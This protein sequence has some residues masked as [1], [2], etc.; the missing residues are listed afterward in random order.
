MLDQKFLRPKNFTKITADSRQVIPGAVFFAISGNKIDGKTYID[1]A[2]KAG[3]KAIVVDKIYKLETNSIEVFQVTDIRSA[4]AEAL[5]EFFDNP[6]KDLACIGVTG[7][8]GKT[9][10]SWILSQALL[11]LGKK[12]A[13]CG[14]LGIGYFQKI[15]EAK[16]SN[17]VD[18]GNTTPDALLVQDFLAQA[19][20]KN[21]NNIVMEVTTHSVD[22]KRVKGVNWD[23]GVFTNISRDHLDY[24][25]TMENYALFKRKFFFEELA[26]SS[27]LNK[28]A[29][30][31]IDDPWGRV[32][33]DDLK[34]K[35]VEVLSYSVSGQ[36]SNVRILEQK[37]SMQGTEIVFLYQEQKHK[38]SANL[39]G[40]YNVENLIAATTALIGLG[41]SLTEILSAMKHV[42]S[43]PGRMQKV[44]ETKLNIFVDYAHTPDALYQVQKSLR[45]IVNG[46]LITIFGCGGDRD[47]GKRPLMGEAVA[48]MSDYAIVTSDNPRSE[49]PDLIVQDIIP[50]IERIKK[51]KTGF[52]YEVVIERKSAI[53]KALDIASDK[54]I[55]LIA[56]KG[57]EDYQIISGVKYPFSDI[58]VCKDLL[59][60]CQLSS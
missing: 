3:A 57:H 8:N 6:S 39:I 26:A 11:A 47:R 46:K 41:Y 34:N 56:G 52:S 5:I 21:I 43:V 29:V 25:Q 15:E 31:N 49:N 12:S 16:I 54:D 30:L 28:K 42:Q 7:T 36:E 51:D 40:N 23:I 60:R 32:I 2:I 48:S 44:P 24:H 20:A 10:V 14:T 1:A 22:Q 4:Y 19:K 35:D 55:I 38:L 18:T 58:E 59:H 50:G 27:K 13:L 33:V 37:L 17:I 45:S 9:S 53:K